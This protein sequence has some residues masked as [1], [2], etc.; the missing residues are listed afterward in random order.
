V[1]RADSLTLRSA[2]QEALDGIADLLAASDLPHQGLDA[3]P[4]EFVAGYADGDLVCGGGVELYGAEALLRSVVVAEDHRSRGYGTALCEELGALAAG[5]GAT[6]CYLLTTT[7]AD[8]FERHRYEEIPRERV[9]DDVLASPLV[10]AHCPVSATC[11][12]RS[13]DE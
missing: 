5:A 12:H 13:I 1:T 4:G 10:A 9:P 11:M 2:D 3:S 8:F 6:D 7:A